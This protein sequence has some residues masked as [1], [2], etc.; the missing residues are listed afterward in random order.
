MSRFPGF[1][2]LIVLPVLVL[3]LAACETPVPEQSLPELTFAHLK[4]IKL[5]VATIEVVSHY[6]Q[7]LKPPNVEHLFPTPPL[8]ALRRWAGDRLKAVG[9]SGSARLIIKKASAVETVL[10][11]KT[12]FTATF[13]KQ[14]SQ[15]YDLSV[16]ATLEIFA[17]GRPRGRASAHATRFSTVREDASI[18]TRQRL[19]FD[20]TE[21]LVRDFDVEMENNIRRHLGAW[22]R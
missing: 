13:T 5:N 2:A 10:K 22:I 17:D 1:F 9:K 18:N 11:K 21:A 16:E 14:Q 15:R 6:K 19:W 20:L 12:G 4:P 7:P 3:G 8:R